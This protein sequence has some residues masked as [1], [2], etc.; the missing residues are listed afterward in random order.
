MFLVGLGF[1]A[2]LVWL[3]IF[4]RP[5]LDSLIIAG[6]L[7]YLLNPL[8][9]GLERRLR[10]NRTAAATVAYGSI[11]LLIILLVTAFGATL[12]NQLP[13]LVD[14]LQTALIEMESWLERPWF[15]LG[16]ELHPE[17]LLASLVRSGGNALASLPTG[18]W[19]VL[20]TI[21]NNLLWSTLVLV[22]LYYFLVDGPKIK[23]WLVSWLPEEY[24]ADGRRLLDE[25]DLIWSVFLRMQLLIFLILAFLLVTSTLLIIWLFR[26]GWLPLSP[27]G[28][29][30]LFILVYTAI[31][32]VDNLWLRPYLLGR[33]LQLHP[34]VVFVGLIAALALSGLLGAIIVVPLLATVKIISR[35]AHA[36]LLGL[37][38]WPPEPLPPT[39]SIIATEA[40][41]AEGEL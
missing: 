28:L 35:Y 36:R 6:L 10:L 1:L 3:L 40:P 34:G 19:E 25:I 13:R 30:I 24:Q 32:Q 18:S 11:T 29:V 17:T 15:I 38:P 41:L 12:W 16:F 31:Q 22:T 8:V 27:L 5:L 2:V 26:S 9:R 33:S 23:P 39:S 14:E 37:P 20:G 21:T 7:A 4:A